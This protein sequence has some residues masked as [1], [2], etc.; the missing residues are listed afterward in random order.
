[1]KRR[2]NINKKAFLTEHVSV[3]IQSKTPIKYKD[4]GYPTI[5]VNIGDTYVEKTLLD[6]GASVNLLPYSVYKQLGLGELKPTSITLTLADRSIKIP[7]GMIEDILVQVDKFYYPVDF[8]ILDTEPI[9]SGPNNVPIIPGRP[10]LAMANALINCWNKVMQ[11]TFGNMPLEL[12]IFHL[13]KRHPNQDEDEQEEF[14]LIDTLIEEHVEGLMNE[15]LEKT[16]E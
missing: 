12:N 4:L 14:C 2:L 15:E 5:S 13:C 1:M 11:L 9:T 6:L 8:I 16:Y 7:R 10:F 3:I